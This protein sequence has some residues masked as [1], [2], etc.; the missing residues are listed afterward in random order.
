LTA[1]KGKK[2]LE[3]GKGETRACFTVET[4]SGPSD[5]ILPCKLAAWRRSR[6]NGFPT[7]RT[8]AHHLGPSAPLSALEPEASA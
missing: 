6:M 8:F 2:N 1:L 3:V 4:F 7:V 5:R